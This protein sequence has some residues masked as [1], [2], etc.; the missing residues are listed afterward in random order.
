MSSTGKLIIARHH[1]SEWNKLGKWTGLRDRHL[2]EYGFK[3]S[4]D[5][6]FLIQDIPID[7]AFAS[8]LVRSIETL[9]CML[10]VCKRYEVP[11]EHSAAL[12]ERDYGDYTGNNKWDMEKMLGEE[13]FQK[14][15]RGWDYP[16]PRGESLKMVYE[17]VVPYFIEKILPRVKEGK[18][19]L[20][21]AHGNSLRTLVKYIENI[22]DEGIA[23]VVVP[24]GA[25][26][27]YELDESGHMVHKEIRQTESNVPA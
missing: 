25:I 16:I 18:N 12:N 13:E 11:T 21:V 24:F 9:S 5:M 20:V 15:R 14:L 19:I 3:K 26:T 10:N 4:E 23:D 22:S 2:D 1:E 27:I 17:R 6:G 7:Y 8:M